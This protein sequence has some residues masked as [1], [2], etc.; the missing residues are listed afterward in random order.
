MTTEMDPFEVTTT[1]EE[2]FTVTESGTKDAQTA[3]TA[4]LYDGHWNALL[5]LIHAAQKNL[6]KSRNKTKLAS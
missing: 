1:D 3:E 6:L 2:L 4:T 5:K